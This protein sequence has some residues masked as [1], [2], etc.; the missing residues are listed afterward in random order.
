MSS[1]LRFDQQLYE[2]IKRNLKKHRV[3]RLQRAG[4]RR[5]AVAFTLINASAPAQIG[6]IP[7][8]S[9]Q[10]DDAAYILTT[11]ASSLSSHAGQRASCSPTH[12]AIEVAVVVPAIVSR[13]TV[14]AENPR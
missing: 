11:R 3:T 10:V 13:G 5:A 12:I 9:A 2:M 7:F 8:D 4:R 6:N 14:A 1:S